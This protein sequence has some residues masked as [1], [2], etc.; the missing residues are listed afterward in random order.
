MSPKWIIST[1]NLDPSLVD[2]K[3][4]SSS[5]HVQNDLTHGQ[6]NHYTTCLNVRESS[7]CECGGN[8]GE[9]TCMCI[10]YMFSPYP[11]T[12][13]IST[14]LVSLPSLQYRDL[15]RNTRGCLDESSR[16]IVS[17]LALGDFCVGR[18]TRFFNI[19]CKSFDTFE[20]H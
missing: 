9:P 2:A 3:N 7:L 11:T 13:R 8:H 20:R 14:R 6:T 18:L 15:P 1:W 19:P 12:G 16:I 5:N 10:H 17:P 4:L